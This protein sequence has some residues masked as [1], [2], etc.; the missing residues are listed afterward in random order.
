MPNSPYVMRISLNVL[1]HLG[2]SLYS[3]T[4]AVLAETIAN[5]WDADA[6]QVAVDV[7]SATKTISVSDNGVGMNL[8]EINQKFLYVGYQKRTGAGEFRTPKGRKPMGRKGI[9][10]LSLFSIANRI[11]V[12]TK[13]KGE[14]PQSFLMD[15]QKIRNEIQTE[16]ASTP[17]IYKPEQ[18]EHD[19][20]IAEHGTILRIA[21]LKKLRI[22]ANTVTG[23]KKRISRRF[24]ILGSDFKILVNGE[25][26]DFS[27]RDYFH[28]ARFIF[29]YGEDYAK[30]C[31]NLD[32]DGDKLMK[33]DRDFRFDENG[34]KAGDGVHAIKGWVAI[35]RR[36]NDL[37]EKSGNEDNLNKITIMVRG[38]VAQEDILHSF[39]LGG[40][41]TK[42]M[43]GEIHADFLDQDD[44][45]DIATSSR[46]TIFEDDPRFKAL[47]SFLKAELKDIWWRTNKLK[48]KKGLEKAL[49]ENLPL[50]EWYDGLPRRLRPR[51]S[52]IFA[53]IDRANIDENE[54]SE[55]YAYGVLAFERLRLHET[56]EILD[57][58]DESNVEAFFEFLDD[59][60]A[61]EAAHYREIVIERLG[62]IQKLQQSV[63]EDKRET[64]LQEYIFEHLWLL[65][66]A[67]ERATEFAKMEER[68]QRSIPQ[69]PGR[70]LRI[71]IRY[72]R[73]AAAHVILELKRASRR[74]HKT[75]IERQLGDYMSAVRKQLKEDSQQIR[76]P[77]EGICIVGRLPIGW[78]EDSEM[79]RKEEDSLRLL[80]I[81][82]LTYTELINNAESAYTKFLKAMSKTQELTS[83]LEDIRNYSPDRINRA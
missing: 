41:I 54:K 62:V 56:A 39:S 75:D 23:L 38:K 48:E 73:V 67:W 4:A 35:A 76:L 68:I 70:A 34:Q 53:V 17:G 74:L 36:S 49:Q 46:Q 81:R 64:V 61:V 6:S 11:S 33:Y 45:D 30:H 31:V 37:D 3:N 40:M 71:D 25:L 66:P 10:K 8:E 24:S 65:D 51:A 15:S 42:Y 28:K 50:K 77:I 57:E 79:R 58:I 69:E 12:Y 27:D 22:T 43:F 9:G 16:N 1:N 5:A 60:D 7:D 63:K 47:K 2:L 44:K 32:K 78:E 80:G 72:R 13:K 19:Q 20:L 83:R 26:V 14:L 18:I 59:V 52:K 21:D 55:F 29:Q 82:V